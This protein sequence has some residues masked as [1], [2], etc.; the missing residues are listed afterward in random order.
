MEP[1]ELTPQ[2]LGKRLRYRKAKRAA[3]LR[4]L[5]ECSTL[6]EK[7]EVLGRKLRTLRASSDC[8]LTWKDI[9]VSLA[10]ATEEGLA[11]KEAL[12]RHL[13]H[14]SRLARH[15]HAW[16]ASMTP[17]KQPA[18]SVFAWRDVH[19]ST[20][21]ELRTVGYHW[22]GQQMLHATPLHIVDS[23]FPADQEDW[24][25]AK[26]SV[27]GGRVHSQQFLD[28]TMMEV[29]IAAWAFSQALP[30]ILNGKRGCVSNIYHHKARGAEIC[31]NR[32]A[33]P[34]VTN[35]GFYTC[36][37]QDDCLVMHY[38]TI[39]YDEAHPVGDKGFKIDIQEWN[40]I[41][42][43]SPT[44]C[45]VQSSTVCQPFKSYEHFEDFVRD[46]H[47]DVLA[48]AEGAQESELERLVASKSCRII[49]DMHGR[50]RKMLRNVQESPE[51]YPTP[52]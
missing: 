9:A 30:T 40:V 10:A 16:V 6:Q 32:E 4:Y 49:R 5:T 13:A 42:A 51:S 27:E 20:N 18:Q 15:L 41:R 36:Y 14:Q 34:W 31:Y 39:R 33:Y 38:R 48:M 28:G 45:V 52:Y 44:K 35:N 47:P 37:V 22:I 25:A 23:D 46:E 2:Q 11:E 19:L 50:V 3:R 43:V 8:L 1:E 17:A 24:V 29:A 7:I 21:V 12:R 26:Y